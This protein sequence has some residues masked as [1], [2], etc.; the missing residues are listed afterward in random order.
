MDARAAPRPHPDRHGVCSSAEA[1]SS[2][3]RARRGAQK[4]GAWSLV[5]RWMGCAGS[6]RDAGLERWEEDVGR[7][8]C[9]SKIK[10]GGIL[11][12]RCASSGIRRSTRVA[13]ENPSAGT[14]WLR[15]RA[16]QRGGCR[17][18]SRVRR[19]FHAP[20]SSAKRPWSVGPS[21]RS[22]RSNW[23]SDGAL[24][25]STRCFACALGRS[26]GSSVSKDSRHL[27]RQL[28]CNRTS[29]PRSDSAP[30]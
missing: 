15:C 28:R 12:S 27:A 6:R 26:G 24:I 4:R 16:R 7:R 5:G 3:P 20:H 19:G 18:L 23:H 10:D 29:R 30:R 25:C 17:K 8:G 22:L 9:E 1:R 21:R 2:L 11:R 14:R 13:A